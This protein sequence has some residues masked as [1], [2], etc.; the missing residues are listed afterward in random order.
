MK[1]A[2]IIG[3]SGQDGAYLAHLLLSKKYEVHGTS[4]D[5]EVNTF[6][7]LR[8][9]AILSRV[10]VHSMA[11]R[12]F[13][14]VMQ[15]VDRVAPDEVYNLGGQSSVGL[16]FSQ[17][18][19]TFE[20]IAVGTINLL[21]ALRILKRPVRFFNAG[22]SECFGNTERPANE[23]TPFHPRSPYATAKSAAHWAVANYRDAYGMFACSSICANHESPLRPTRFVT[24]KIVQAAVQIARG[25][26]C[27]ELGD[28]NIQRDWGWAPDY[29]ECF[30]R[31]LQADK[32]AD[33]VI[34]SGTTNTL[35]DFVAEAFD[36]VSLD[37]RDHV[38]VSPELMRPSEISS[39]RL[40]PSRVAA[41]LG[42]RARYRMREIVRLLV[43]S[44]KTGGTGLGT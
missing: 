6:P 5:S 30:W 18:V 23:D 32:P 10:R 21:D 43:D 38:R 41:E 20:S 25:G 9:L 40:D 15:I 1:K 22:S 4:R 34:A 29:V 13:R 42:W 14:S 17:P 2:L 19:E 36:A 33:Y 27:L 39:S 24:R 26:G 16:S 11:V 35:S 44:E 28:M 7:A 37:W 8:A 3:I 12:D 31:M